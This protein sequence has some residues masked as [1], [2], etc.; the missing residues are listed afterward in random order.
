MSQPNILV[1]C[2]DEHSRD[3][4]GCYGSPI[5]IS[6][7]LDAL[8]AR[9]I[10]FSKAYTTSPL[11]V[12]ARSSLVT[13]R[14][15][16]EIGC[17]DNG[18]PYHGIPRGWTHHL[19]EAGWHVASIGKNHYRSVGD[20]NGFSEELLPMHVRE[21]VG[22][23][24]GMLRKQGVNYPSQS[25]SAA[26]G[27][28]TGP[29][30]MA[31]T[32]GPGESNHTDYDER[33]TQAACDWLG[34]RAKG[35]SQPWALYVSMVSPHFPLIAP[36]RFY[37]IYPQ[38]RLPWPVDHEA[39]MRSKHPVV[40]AMMRM[41]NY[42]DYFDASKMRRAI[43]A[44]LGLVSFLDDNIGRILSALDGAGML[45]NTHVI[46]MSDHGEML[47]RKGIW[48]CSAMYEP[49]VSVP[50]IVAG[51]GVAV[52]NVCDTEVSHIDIFPTILQMA[53]IDGPQH[54]GPGTSLLDIGTQSSKQRIAFSEYHAGASITGCYMVRTGRWKYIEYVGY[55]P[56]LF[57][58]DTDPNELHNLA[59]QLAFA[60]VQA[61]CSQ[62]LRRIVDPSA[63]NDAAFASQA[64]AVERFG[65]VE[66]VVARGHPGEHALDRKLGV[67]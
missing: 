5:V 46:Y 7:N 65:G 30:M 64:A 3:F 58:L 42:D 44:Y 41:W 36:K 37:D 49:S 53:E 28:I 47:G 66:K 59:G 34:K 39:A 6:P 12:P 21:G 56:E 43:A 15:V 33:I 35:S 29:A 67:E 8:A 57:D 18:H 50:Y 19:R 13:G 38:D 55:E 45:G 63:A 31:E 10:R 2:S 54:S 62:A 61:A 23:L 60:G 9:G 32:A 1:L 17:W 22:D 16:H 14:Y 27:L 40:Q 51:P 52:P 4:L 26:K 25:A 48:S 20:D 24:I 11:C